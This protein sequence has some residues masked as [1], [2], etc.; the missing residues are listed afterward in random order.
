MGL[1]EKRALKAFQDEQYAK[2]LASVAR[3]ARKEV[4]IDV[5]WDA[6]SAHVSP[7]RAGAYWSE[8]FF[9]PVVA[10]LEKIAADRFGRDALEEQ[11]VRVRIKGSSRHVYQVSWKTGALTVDLMMRDDSAIGGPGTKTFNDR[12]AAIAACLEENL[13]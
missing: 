3:I 7:E 10:A 4:P 12:V 6:L 5:D 8:S 13:G 11:L 2:C 1:A 9:L